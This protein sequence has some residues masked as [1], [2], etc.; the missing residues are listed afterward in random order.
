MTVQPTDL[1]TVIPSP[2]PIRL[3]PGE[4][5]CFDCG[6]PVEDPNARL[7]EVDA[8]AHLGQVPRPIRPTP[9]PLTT[10]E[11]RQCPDCHARADLG[12]AILARHPYL[13]RVNGPARDDLVG[14]ALN[15]LAALQP[16]RPLGVTGTDE[17]RLLA[18]DPQLLDALLDRMAEVGGSVPW[19]RRFVPFTAADARPDTA[20]P[21]PWAHLTP[22]Q[23]AR[24]RR[25]EA[26]LLAARVAA[27]AVDLTLTPPPPIE[28]GI[29]VSTGCL[30][31]G[32]AT[33]TVPAS[34]VARAGGIEH[35]RRRAWRPIA[36]QLD[37]LGGWIRPQ[38]VTGHLCQPCAEIVERLGSI[39]ATAMEQSLAARLDAQGR[40]RDAAKVRNGQT[41]GLLGWAVLALRGEA[42]NAEPWDHIGDIGLDPDAA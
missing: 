33:L 12:R 23:T 16:D 35:A 7:I 32:V 28:R 3:R 38:P 6:V 13:R 41:T 17:E 8:V 26:D 15:A 22:E 34:D 36:A 39:G 29:P 14:D 25:A 19:A 42:P 24:L 4:L 1:P 30:L 10:F 27:N 20:N 9:E 40:T 11:F 37:A 5:A 2:R 21:Y 31:C 18:G